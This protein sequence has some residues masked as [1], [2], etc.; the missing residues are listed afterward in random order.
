MMLNSIQK[1][2]FKILWLEGQTK[3]TQHRAAA[4]LW[5]DLTDRA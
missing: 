5:D 2:G 1:T 3:K 4:S